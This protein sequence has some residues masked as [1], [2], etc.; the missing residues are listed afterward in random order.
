[1]HFVVM[2]AVQSQRIKIIFKTK[3]KG[4]VK[5]TAL[6]D[7]VL[8]FIQ[9]FLFSKQT[10]TYPTAHSM[11]TTNLLQGVCY[12]TILK[13]THTLISREMLLFQQVP[14]M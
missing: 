8:L 3:W 9:V 1:M 13:H 12:H 2:L 5:C 4:Q 11:H 14:Q 10:K 6:W 7:T